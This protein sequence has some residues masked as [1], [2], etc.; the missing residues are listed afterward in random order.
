MVHVIG[1]RPSI[2]RLLSGSS[3]DTNLVGISSGSSSSCFSELQSVLLP[4]S[5]GSRRSIGA[6]SG[7]GCGGGKGSNSYSMR[8]VS[9]SVALPNRNLKPQSRF[10][11]GCCRTDNLREAVLLEK[12]YIGKEIR[13]DRPA[14]FIDSTEVFNENIL[15][16]MD[17]ENPL[18]SIK[19]G[20]GFLAAIYRN[21]LFKFLVYKYSL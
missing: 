10:A 17:F 12:K 7:S 18:R 2:K 13:I 4:S 19:I 3:S 9:S 16:F 1:D 15:F 14:E 5:I 6:E 8:R 20:L 11:E 21:R